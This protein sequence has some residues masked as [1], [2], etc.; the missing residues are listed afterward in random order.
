MTLNIRKMVLCSLFASLIALCS[1]ICIPIPPVSFTMQTFAVLMSLSVLG[2]KWGS[3]SILLYL[4][5]GL[6]G[7]PVFSGFRGGAAALLDSTGGFLWGFLAGSLG[8]WAA[9]KLSRLP[10]MILCQLF[11]YSCGCFWF[12]HWAGCGS[13][14]ALLSCVFPY[15]VPD[16]LKLWLAWHLSGQ[17]RR[18]LKI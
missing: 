15:L 14:V 9:E 6:I 18:Q 4:T 5:M 11:C 17:I 10:A 16:G 2:G 13:D 8:Y 7:L 12:S 1:W 3:V